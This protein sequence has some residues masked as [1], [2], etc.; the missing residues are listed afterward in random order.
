MSEIIDLSYDS[1]TRRPVGSRRNYLGMFDTYL[2]PGV[3]G[4]VKLIYGT[5]DKPMKHDM[6]QL[7]GKTKPA[8][9]QTYRSPT[10]IAE[11]AGFYA[12]L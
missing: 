11:A 10:C 2:Q 7:I 9:I 5:S 12:D 8:A 6:E 4:A 3:A 1:A